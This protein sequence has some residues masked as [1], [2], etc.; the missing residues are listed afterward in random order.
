M[1]AE[2]AR[3]S[4]RARQKF[5]GSLG[6]LIILL[7][8]KKGSLAIILPAYDVLSFVCH[9]HCDIRVPEGVT[10]TARTPPVDKMCLNG[11]R[12][13]LMT[14]GACEWTASGG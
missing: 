10:T 7:N 5:I 12:F 13:Y 11:A 4:G 3:R 1:A 6:W 14:R 2:R 8:R 9:G